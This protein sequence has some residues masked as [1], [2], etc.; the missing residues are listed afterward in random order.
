MN[1]SRLRRRPLWTLFLTGAHSWEQGNL[2]AGYL[3]VGGARKPFANTRTT[4]HA[5]H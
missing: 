4:A 5:T 3:G 1:I 2:V